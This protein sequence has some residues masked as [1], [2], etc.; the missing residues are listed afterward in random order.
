MRLSV[1]KNQEQALRRVVVP[2][3]AFSPGQMT[4]KTTTG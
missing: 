3:E 1:A 4:A 2:A